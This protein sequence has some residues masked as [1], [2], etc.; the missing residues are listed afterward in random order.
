MKIESIK[1]KNFRTIDE[2]LTIDL[3]GSLT[4][5]G[6]NSSGKTNILKAV[7]MLFTG[8]ENK[9]K[10]LFERDFPKKLDSGQTSLVGTFV[11]DDE[12]EEALKLYNDINLCLET[13]KSLSRSINVYLTFSRSGKPIYRLFVGEKH[14]PKKTKE[15]NSLQNKLINIILDS[16][17]CHYV[18]SVK[19]TH[20]LFNELLLPSIRSS[21]SE[22]LGEK[23][24]EIHQGLDEISS[25]IDKQ[26]DLVGLGHIR[27]QFKLP[28]NTLENILSS[29]E[30]HLSDPVETIIESK[31]M[32]VQ[33]AAIFAAFSWITKRERDLGKRSIW[34]I[35][36]PESYLHPELSSSC[37]LMLNSLSEEG[38]LIRTT[39]SLKF[40]PQ[41][42]KRV[43]G[44][45]V[46][47][48][49]TR[50]RTYD[51]YTE[52]TKSIRSALGVKFS[53][54]MN[55]G[56][57]NIF[58]EGKTDRELFQWVLSKLQVKATGK[59]SWDN[60]R[61]AEFID[62]GGT[63]ALEGFMKATYEYVS[64]ERATVVILDGDDA[65]D[66]TRKNLQG[67]FGKKGINFDFNKEFIMLPQGFAIEGLF[68][69][70]WLIEAN[71]EHPNWFSGF[72]LD[73]HNKLLPFTTK[74][75]NNKG[76][77]REYLKRKAESSENDDWA[78]SF[79]TLFDLID[80]SLEKTSEKISASLNQ[81]DEAAA[82]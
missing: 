27:A 6:P 44:T 72:S 15:F 53:D 49:Y 56:I 4:I 57:L 58:V 29:F 60:V 64:K 25:T 59:Y 63:S 42:P 13:P 47:K 80:S 17:V 62:F 69:E 5:V 55:L 38:Y 22:I 82:A 61:N 1:I 23:L 78:S 3:D 33:S 51:T 65:G 54:Y 35:E 71:R 43:I 26:L 21:I 67:F 81:G 36:E 9:N 14:N 66:K 45:E 40:V 39:H 48:G 76:Q 12:S 41:D 7:E 31:G 18:S 16:F 79:I 74:N 73:M 32:G 24:P 46:E 77:L 50:T 20:E 28:N 11:L 34:L 75:E 68:P 37:N 10:Y 70:S 8:F 19:N 30:Y 2:E 52:S